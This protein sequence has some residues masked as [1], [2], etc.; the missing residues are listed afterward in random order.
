L[1]NPIFSYPYWDNKKNIANFEYETSFIK[2]GI[3]IS[4]LTMPL[5]V[6]AFAGPLSEAT[7]GRKY[8]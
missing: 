7:K 3:E 5:E 2:S 6:P 8:S 4:P 1:Q